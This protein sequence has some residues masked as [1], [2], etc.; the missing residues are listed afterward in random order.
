MSP[1][2]CQA[3]DPELPQLLIGIARLGNRGPIIAAALSSLVAHAKGHGVET[4][5][6]WIEEDSGLLHTPSWQFWPVPLARL[7]KELRR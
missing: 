3:P 5:L 6:A 2:L 7:I 1:A 4:V